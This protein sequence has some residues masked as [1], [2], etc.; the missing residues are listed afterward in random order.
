MLS[1]ARSPCRHFAYG[2]GNSLLPITK[3]HG[4]ARAFLLITF[5]HE[6][7]YTQ[8]ERLG[9]WLRTAAARSPCWHF[10]CGHGSSL[11]PRIE[12]HGTARAFCVLDFT[13][14]RRTNAGRTEC[15]IAANSSVNDLSLGVFGWAPGGTMPAG[16]PRAVCHLPFAHALKEA[17]DSFQAGK[18][19]ILV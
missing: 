15:P 13:H 8:C 12:R 6:E 10:A 5:T 1:L 11:L 19:A 2:H 7:E 17:N 16:A 9:Q 4:T 3:R 18:Y 14:D